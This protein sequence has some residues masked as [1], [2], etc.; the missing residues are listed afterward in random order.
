MTDTARDT[1]L[2]AALDAVRQLAD[3][4]ADA[5]TRG[6]ELIAAALMK[7]GVLQAFGTGHSRAVA[8]ELTGRAG[9]LVPANQLAIRDTVYYGGEPVESILDPLVERDLSLAHRIWQLADI[10]P[11][12]IFVIISQSGG[13]G[14]VVEMAQLA[15]SRGHTVIGLTSMAHT[16][17]IT[18]RHPSGL[19]LADLA[20]VVIDNGSPYGDAAVPA[21]GETIGPLSTLTGVL[22]AQLLVAEVAD[23]M[24]AAGVRPPVLRSLNVPDTEKHN[25]LLLARYAGRVR[26]G[27]A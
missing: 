21:G 24:A 11:E 9:G 10:R 27:D 26:L 20:D 8:L 17:R 1:F 15:K 7:G 13:N 14:S 12:D 19:R 25:D 23:R 3:S 18:S 22:A 5:I 6:G 2:A 16:R 4:Q